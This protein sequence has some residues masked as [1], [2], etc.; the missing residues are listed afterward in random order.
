[1]ILQFIRRSLATYVKIMDN[2]NKKLAVISHNVN[3]KMFSFSFYLECSQPPISRQFNMSRSNEESMK[4]FHHR[5][6]ENLMKVVLKKTKK[7]AKKAKIDSDDNEA[8]E[9][10]IKFMKNDQVLEF[11]DD[12]VAQDFLAQ[13]GLQMNILNIAFDIVLDPP[14]VL[15]V[16]LPDTILAGFLM[17][18]FKLELSNAEQSNC[19][20]LWYVSDLDLEIKDVN[21]VEQYKKS[22][23]T[24]RH[25]G[26]FYNVS[27]DDI[28]RYVK[29][30][31]VPKSGTKEGLKYDIYR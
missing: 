31:I 9:V 17:Y 10:P 18:P 12:Q 19:D 25:Q 3:T 23:W 28:D 1:M 29:L 27:N 20:F 21:N 24:F 16:K 30:V 14:M 8:I 7:K 2:S 26:F 11:Q 4:N 5:L 22:G 6:K 15:N 13:D